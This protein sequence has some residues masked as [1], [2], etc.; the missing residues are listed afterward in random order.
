ME[1]YL[2]ALLALFCGIV[3]G[4]LIGIIPAAGATTGLV[5]LFPFIVALKTVDPYIAVI[6]IVAVVASS[7][8]GDT[9]TS[10]LLGIPG[11]NSSA[12]TMVDGFPLA[13]QGK[14]TYALSAAVT[15]STVN[16]LF[17]GSIAFLLM[18]WYYD[19]IIMAPTEGGVGQAELFALC[20]LAFVTVTF[21]STKFWIRSLL[22]L[23]FGVF[24]SLVGTDP[25]TAS[26]RFTMGWDFLMGDG[27]GKGISMI[28]VIAG[29]FAM[30]EMV[31]ALKNKM[32]TSKR[33][34]R[35]H[36]QQLNDGIKISFKEWKLSAKGGVIGA[37]VGFLPGLG[38]GMSDWLAYGQ[39]VAT[40]PNEK[41][42]FGKGN[43]KGVIGPEGSNNSQKASAFIPTV[44]FGIPGAP[45][46][47]IVIGLFGAIGFELSLGTDVMN[48]N[49]M[50]NSLFFD[51]LSFGFLA[52]TLL[53]GFICLYLM[54]Y[55]T[56][57][58]YVPYKYYF[59]VLLA[60][61]VWA[62][63]S[64]G[65]GVYGWENVFLLFVFTLVG[66]GMRK[67]KFSRPA[68]MIGFIL[69]DKIEMLG[70]QFFNMFNVGGYPLI[71]LSEFFTGKT[72]GNGR[73]AMA[74]RDGNDVLQHPVFV[75]VSVLIL[76]VLVWGFKNKGKVDYS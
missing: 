38:G 13:Q 36:K 63:Y 33:S 56:A 1:F 62:T 21:V 9:F 43:I 47:A 61:I 12:A 67:W 23:T 14:A 55:L 48:N 8:T 30:P 58:A 60:F 31:L 50:E 35:N 71:K 42:P 27:N 3:Y 11:A 72:V 10:V 75:V 39:T 40:N 25:I 24:L 41:I 66:L 17:W 65:F 68:L 15:T 69:G 45:F 49:L 34:D 53:T 76:I 73:L 20:V 26:P 70:M 5:A 19:F 37:I 6:F 74:L 44:L 64:A 32:L 52:S 54:K 18:P 22:A 46:A 16:G 2:L 59:P 51:S 57:I 28:P 4:L 7:T 29:I